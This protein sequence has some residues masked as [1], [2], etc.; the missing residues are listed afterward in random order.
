ME[1]GESFKLGRGP[2]GISLSRAVVLVLL[3]TVAGAVE[4]IR[5]SSLHDANVWVHLRLGDWILANKTWPTTGLFSQDSNLAW[6]D[7]TWAADM[8]MAVA[9]RVLGLAA[10]PALWVVYRFLLAVVTFLLAGGSRENLWLPALLTALAQY[11]LYGLGPLEA[12]NSALLFGV[13]LFVLIE[14]RRSRRLQHLF[15]LPLL[16]VVWA[17]VELGFVYGIGLLLLFFGSLV[18]DG[19]GY[20]RKA[21]LAAETPIGTTAVVAGACLLATLF[22]PYGYHS[23]S[24]FFALQTSTANKYLPA[25]TAMTFHQPQDYV[26]LLLTMA[27]FFSLGV[28]RSRDP[29]LFPVL[30]MC[31]VLSFHAQGENWLATLAA[32]AVIG[33]ELPAEEVARFQPSVARFCWRE[34]L[35]PAASSL[36]V[37]LFLYVLWVPR[38]RV[39]LLGRVSNDF[40]V[41]ACDYIRQHQLPAPLFNS[42]A[43]GGFLTWYLPE[44]PVA[45]DARRSLYPDDSETDYFKVMKVDIPYQSFPP[46]R[47]ARTFLLDRQSVMGDA[48]RGLPGFQVAYG[49]SISIVLLREGETMAASGGQTEEAAA[50]KTVP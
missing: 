7:F 3:F 38:Q 22:S 32:I 15:W 41:R 42:Y 35:L 40:P 1:N 28:K 9:F 16:F 37:L 46:M 34:L 12:G 6:R 33:N 48:L 5:L 13:L 10:V 45:I 25:H 47:Q 8:V 23:Y 50:A 21:Q 27:A 11:L 36:V 14:V 24:T 44:Y 18:V 29:F 31:T 17:N 49:D 30:V 4:T 43:W 39:V 20:G 26:L 2:F 19:V